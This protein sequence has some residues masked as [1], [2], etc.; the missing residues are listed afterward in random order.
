MIER[1]EEVVAYL[2]GRIPSYSELYDSMD[3][4]RRFNS[5]SLA[6]G[7]FRFNRAHGLA[8]Y[9]EFVK[10]YL[11]WE[12]AGTLDKKRTRDVLEK[13]VEQLGGVP[14][15]LSRIDNLFGHKG[16]AFEEAFRRHYG[17]SISRYCN[18]NGIPRKSCKGCP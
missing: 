3:L 2:K 6:G 8:S 7:I 11:G 12:V 13:L 9:R 16:H 18:Q 1:L 5:C 14:F 17:I 15:G 10:R 4:R